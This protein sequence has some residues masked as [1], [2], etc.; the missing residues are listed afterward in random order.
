MTFRRTTLFKRSY[1]KLEDSQR[2][3]IDTALLR[4]AEQPFYP[5]HPSLSMHKLA[6]VYGTPS[7]I[8]EPRPA[9]WEFHAS[10]ALLVTFQY[11]GSDEILLRNCGYHDP[12][13]RSP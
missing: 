1:R 11:Q 8:G 4:L 7:R 13:L 10:D 12:V 9:I 2:V 5:F 6:G 3:R